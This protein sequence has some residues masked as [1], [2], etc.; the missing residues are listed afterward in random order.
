M[1]SL[2]ELEF[3][4]F[5]ETLTN[6]EATLSVVKTLSELYIVLPFHLMIAMSIFSPTT[7]KMHIRMAFVSGKNSPLISNEHLVRSI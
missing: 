2:E 1:L 7:T 5:L 3:L 6:Y 4:N